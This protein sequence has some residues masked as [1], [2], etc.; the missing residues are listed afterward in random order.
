[1]ERSRV[2]IGIKVSDYD[3][4][5]NRNLDEKGANGLWDLSGDIALQ[6]GLS[7]KE[8]NILPNNYIVFGED[9]GQEI[10][11]NV[12][13]DLKEYFARSVKNEY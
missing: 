10:I 9:L 3:L 11:Y 7:L 2:D 1:M 5:L 8:V 12:I 6:I 13:Q 4:S